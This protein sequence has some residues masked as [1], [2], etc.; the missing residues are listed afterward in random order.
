MVSAYQHVRFRLRNEGKYLHKFVLSWEKFLQQIWVSWRVRAGGKFR[1][2]RL[3]SS[4]LILFEG[5]VAQD[6]RKLRN[7]RI[8]MSLRKS[9]V[10]SDFLYFFISSKFNSV[11]I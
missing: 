3:L 6:K 5:R 7:R 9:Q 2:L 4:F 11:E 1:G 8:F 10:P